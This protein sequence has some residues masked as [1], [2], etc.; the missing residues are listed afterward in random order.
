MMML[1]DPPLVEI[2]TA[3]SSGCACAISWRRKIASVPTSLATAVMFAG[4]SDSDT[5]GTGLVSGRRKHAVD[6]PVVGVGRRSAIAEQDEFAAAL[7][8]LMHRHRRAADLL[9]LLVAPPARAASRHRELS[10]GSR[11]QLRASRSSVPCFS[12]P[13]TDRGT[14]TAHVVPELAVLEEDVHCLPQRV[15]EHLDHLLVHEG[16]LGRDRARRTLPVP[17]RRRSSRPQ[18]GLLQR[19]P[20]FRIAFRRAESHDDIFGLKYGFE[21]GTEQNREI[22][23][24][25]RALAHDHGMNKFHRDVLGIGGVGPRPKASRRPPRRKRSDISRQ[26]SARRGPRARRTVRDVRSARAAALH[27]TSASLT[28]QS[29]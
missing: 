10:S 18:L 9:G 7:Q 12:V 22:E 21:P 29:P 1:L 19:G 13:G 28:S 23:S 3:T 27:L 20:D 8:T 6:G 14:P 16:I 5:A 17:G 26:A 15:V 2:A 24:R 4:S 11:R 25:Q